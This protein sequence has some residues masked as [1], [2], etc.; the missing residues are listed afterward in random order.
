MRSPSISAPDGFS[1]IEL[2]LVI[3]LM[4]AAAAGL[5]LG[6][7]A[8]VFRLRR[9][10]EATLLSALRTARAE[11]M[12]NI[13]RADHGVHYDPASTCRAYARCFTLFEGDRFDPAVGGVEFE[14]N[15]A[16]RIG[17]PERDPVF[18]NL[19]GA[20]EPAAI[21]LE[22]GGRVTRIDIGYEGRID[23]R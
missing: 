2:I 1:L 9:S 14:S 17:W 11:A 22:R 18:R 15:G 12:R 20:A 19:D 23:A 21:S 10:E 4:A 8:L 13:G 16:V 6:G 7:E 3:G 5:G